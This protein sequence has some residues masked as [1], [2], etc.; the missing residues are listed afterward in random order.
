LS[1]ESKPLPVAAGNEGELGIDCFPR[2][3]DV[4]GDL[5]MRLVR[6]PLDQ[7]LQWG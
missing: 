2:S 5:G 7:P 6:E 4:G 1:G 3:L